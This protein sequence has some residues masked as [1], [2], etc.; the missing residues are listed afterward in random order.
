MYIQDILH[1]DKGGKEAEVIVSDGVY[2]VL[3]YAFPI[4]AVRIGMAISGLSGYSCSNVVRAVKRRYAVSKL[5]P[6][7][8]YSMTGKVF[9]IQER[10]IH[11]GDLKVSLDAYI[12]N[13]IS[14]GEY[15]S[16]D[17]QR[18]DLA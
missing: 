9:S 3:C 2:E 11:V 7:F 8:A 18:L 13:D 17:V 10:I 12:P 14:N 4:D 1:F 5:S 15:V 6:Y 16:F